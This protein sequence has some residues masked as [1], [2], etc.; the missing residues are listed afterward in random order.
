[1][2]NHSN[3]RRY[4]LKRQGVWYVVV[5]TLVFLGVYTAFHYAYPVIHWPIF[6]IS[7]TPWEHL[8]IGFFGAALLALAEFVLFARSRIHS[9][10]RFLCS[11]FTGIIL[12]PLTLFLFYYLSVALFG[13]IAPTWLKVFS[14]V[15]V[16]LLAG[17]TAFYTENEC[18]ELPLEMKPS[19]LLLQ[20]VILIITAFLFITF[21]YRLPYYPLF[22]EV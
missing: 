18:L 12:V 22:M 10:F 8:K 19:L 9:W 4:A 15:F 2:V 6:A 11:R 1:M 14:V 20:V 13:R 21:T 3:E 7:E 5:K 16:T 17:L